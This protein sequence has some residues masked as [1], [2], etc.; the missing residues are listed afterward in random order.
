MEYQVLIQLSKVSKSSHMLS[1]FGQIK[2]ESPRSFQHSWSIIRKHM[3]TEE[4]RQNKVPHFFAI[5]CEYI[6]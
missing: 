6:A 1:K 4:G 5:F 3:L 2:P